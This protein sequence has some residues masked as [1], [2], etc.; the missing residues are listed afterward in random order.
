MI[1]VSSIPKPVSSLP[2]IRMREEGRKVYVPYLDGR[3]SGVQVLNGYGFGGRD[4]TYNAK[5]GLSTVLSTFHVSWFEK[6]KHFLKDI[7]LWIGRT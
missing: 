1:L 2:F 4:S 5:S 3:R 6:L 7:I